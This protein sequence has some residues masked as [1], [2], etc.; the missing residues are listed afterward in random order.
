KFAERDVKIDLYEAQD[1]IITAGAGISIGLHPNQIMEELGMHEEVSRV[2]T[3][4][5]PS[6]GMM[7]RKSDSQEGVFEWFHHI[8]KHCQ[9]T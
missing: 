8:S 9:W 2:S 6:H 3:K 5:S 7:Y 1:A 4:P